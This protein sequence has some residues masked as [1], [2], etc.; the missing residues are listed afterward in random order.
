[1]VKVQKVGIAVIVL[2]TP[3]VL[4]FCRLQILKCFRSALIN[5][6][7]PDQSVPTGVV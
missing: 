7:D 5:N 6:V 3:L 4:C 2:G 1:M